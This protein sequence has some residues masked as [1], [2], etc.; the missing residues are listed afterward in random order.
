MW[1]G[2]AAG[3]AVAQPVI[4]MNIKAVIVANQLALFI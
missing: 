4:R 3:L 1:V 2:A